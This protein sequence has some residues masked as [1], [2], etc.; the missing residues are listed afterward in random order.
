VSVEHSPTSHAR[1]HSDN[2]VRTSANMLDIS[3]ELSLSMSV[4]CQFIS[5]N[6]C[7]YTTEICK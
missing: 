2:D 1:S 7:N 5:G 4:N 6:K 3:L